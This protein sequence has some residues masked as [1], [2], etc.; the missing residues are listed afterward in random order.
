MQLEA[1]WRIVGAVVERR[2]LT[3]EKNATWRGH[4]C[5]V[6]TFGFCAELQLSAEQFRQVAE[7]MYIEARG[8]FEDNKGIIRLRCTAIGPGPGETGVRHSDHGVAGKVG[9]KP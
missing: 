7:G 6:A 5:K 8:R 1:D 9:P 3:S 2:E 4:V